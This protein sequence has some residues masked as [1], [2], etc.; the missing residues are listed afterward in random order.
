[1]SRSTGRKSGMRSGWNAKPKTGVTTTSL[2]ILDWPSL[3][4]L[5][6]KFKHTNQSFIMFCVILILQFTLFV[7]LLCSV[8]QVSPKVRKVLQLFRL[9]QINNGTFVKLNKATINMLRICE[10]Y[11]TWGYPNLKSVRELIYKRGFAK[12]N[13]QRIPITSNETIEKQLGNENNQFIY[14]LFLF[15]FI[16]LTII[17]CIKILILVFALIFRPIQRHLYGGFDPRD[18]HR[19]T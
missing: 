5:E 2:V 1:M 13:H 18:F 6:G 4:V 3:F 16:F 14:L 15:L 12:I 17:W 8:N 7:F 9:R 10:P 11:I 19:W